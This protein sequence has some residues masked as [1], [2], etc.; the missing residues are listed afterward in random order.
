MV[1]RDVP[2]DPAVGV[3]T[4]RFPI[5]RVRPAGGGG[6]IGSSPEAAGRLRCSLVLKFDV[7]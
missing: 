6:R 2:V 3:G 1:P 5:S 4:D 7:T